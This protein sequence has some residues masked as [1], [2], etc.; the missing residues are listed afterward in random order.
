MHLNFGQKLLVTFSILLVLVMAAFT[1]SSNLRLQNTTETYVDALIENTV[2]QNT[3]SIADWLNTRLKMTEATAKA[4]ETVRG[5]QQARTLLQAISAGGVTS[6]MCMSAV[7][8][9]TCS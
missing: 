5:D 7:T 2:E 8:M 1:I 4:L 3:S 6:R 9:A